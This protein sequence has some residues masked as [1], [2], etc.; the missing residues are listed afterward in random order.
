MVAMTTTRRRSQ[1][2]AVFAGV[3]RCDDIEPDPNDGAPSAQGPSSKH[4][5][6]SPR[7]EQRL[8]AR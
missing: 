4:L 2:M 6:T 3:N 1:N 7:A 5:P 8:I